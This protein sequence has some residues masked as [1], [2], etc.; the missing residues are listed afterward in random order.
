MT[1]GA[2]LARQAAAAHR[3]DNVVL[4]LALGG[5]ERLLARYQWDCLLLRGGFEI[6]ESCDY[7]PFLLRNLLPFGRRETPTMYLATVRKATAATSRRLAVVRT[8]PSDTEDA[9]TIDDVWT[10]AA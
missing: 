3:A 1:H 2:G 5:D 6:V 9:V 10:R 4:A 7:R 8:T